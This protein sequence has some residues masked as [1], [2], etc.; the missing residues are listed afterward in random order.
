VDLD[1][2]PE[3]ASGAESEDFVNIGSDADSSEDWTV[4]SE[5]SA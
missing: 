1:S 5:S 2:N 3:D 4:L